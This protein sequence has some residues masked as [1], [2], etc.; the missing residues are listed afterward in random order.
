MSTMQSVLIADVVQSRSRG[1]LRPILEARLREA[2][3]AHR[4]AKIIRLP[5]AVTAGDEFQCLPAS[6]G[7]I[8]ELIFDLRR[9]M[10]PLSLRIGIGIGAI[11]GRIQPPVN[12]L[13]GE[14]FTRARQAI[15][16]VKQGTLHR[17]RVLT[18]FRTP[19]ES[20]DRLANLVYGL[21]DTLLLRVTETQWRTMGAYREKRRVDRAAK[22]LRLDSST[23]SR[24]LKRAHYW[25][26]AETAA[27]MRSLLQAEWGS[28]HENVQSQAI[29]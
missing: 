17:Y 24:S 2:S 22:R 16:A 5:Y 6:P 23:A 27:V 1:R 14:A 13:T 19:Q 21:T 20:F 8:P 9:R 7:V 28:L 11:E 15:D 18:A 12:R 26:L 29:A 25:Q 10:R 4:R 3:A